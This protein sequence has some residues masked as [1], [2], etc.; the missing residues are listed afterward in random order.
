VT[1]RNQPDHCRSPIDLTAPGPQNG[2]VSGAQPTQ[3][4]T[5]AGYF[6]FRP[7]SLDGEDQSAGP[8][9]TERQP[10]QP[11]HGRH[12]AR[13]HDIRGQLPRQVFRP[14]ATDLSVAQA[15]HPD[16]LLKESRSPF[17]PLQ[18]EHFNVW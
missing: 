13:G 17:H 4:G 6:L 18:Q 5:R 1:A 11:F 16:A 12:R 14:A 8:H 2:H 10:S 15:E 7:G 3:H 9:Q